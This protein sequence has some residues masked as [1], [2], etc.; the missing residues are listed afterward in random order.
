MD[1]GGPDSCCT[2]D[3]AAAWKCTSDWSFSKSLMSPDPL[4]SEA[5]EGK[6]AAASHS[7]GASPPLLGEKLWDMARRQG[8]HAGKRKRGFGLCESP[9]HKCKELA[10]GGP[11]SHT[12]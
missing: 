3:K 8:E 11:M 1:E 7:S 9:H 2:P 4:L 6:G 10:R 5:G 12:R